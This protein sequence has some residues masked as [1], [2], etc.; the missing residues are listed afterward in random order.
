MGGFSICARIGAY[1]VREA[2]DP[3]R[4]HS[5]ITRADPI[6]I[7]VTDC[8]ADP[9]C[10]VT[11]RYPVSAAARQYELLAAKTRVLSRMV[12]ALRAEIR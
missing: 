10:V 6:E 1:E 3:E 4:F 9:C 2:D 7:S 12:D 5:L 8:P 11:R